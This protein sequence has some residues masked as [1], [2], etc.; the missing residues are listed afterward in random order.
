M[1]ASTAHV[2][3]GNFGEERLKNISMHVPL[4]PL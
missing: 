1:Y 3:D 2:E 4:Y